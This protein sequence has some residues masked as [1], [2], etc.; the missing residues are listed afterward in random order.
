MS[1]PM[2]MH[3]RYRILNRDFTIVFINI[4]VVVVINLTLP[5]KNTRM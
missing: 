3:P 2:I 5:S 1:F 4:I